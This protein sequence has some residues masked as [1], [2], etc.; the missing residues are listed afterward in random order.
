MIEKITVLSEFL[1]AHSNDPNADESGS[2]YIQQSDIREIDKVLRKLMVLFNDLLFLITETRDRY[3][4]FL[5]WLYKVV[6]SGT[7]E[8]AERI[9]SASVLA[10]FKIDKAK[11]LLHCQSDDTFLLRHLVRFFEN[12]SFDLSEYKFDYFSE[13]LS[14]DFDMFDDKKNQNHPRM[15]NNAYINVGC[16]ELDDLFES[17]CGIRL[18]QA[19]ISVKPLEYDSPI[20]GSRREE[21][22]KQLLDMLGNTVNKINISHNEAIKRQLKLWKNVKNLSN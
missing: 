7:P 20:I 1:E 8:A 3:V 18:E 16:N 11:L 17:T 13:D 4:N 21:S 9:N 19:P 2:L 10:T 15:E 22:I 12:S 6:S 5:A 14:N